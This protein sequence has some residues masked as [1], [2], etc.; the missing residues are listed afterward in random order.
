MLDKLA[1]IERRYEELNRLMADPE[2][3]VDHERVAAL[4]QEQAGLEGLVKA[5]RRYQTVEKELDDAQVLLED[6]T[7][8]EIRAEIVRAAA[9]YRTE[10]TAGLLRAALDDPDT[11]VRIAA[12]NALGQ[13]GDAEAVRSLSGVLASDLDNDV[14]LAAVAALG[15]TGDTAA[16]PALGAA[17]EELY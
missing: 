12:C 9:F 13:Q 1:G 5:Y 11:D 16:V 4:A 2:V 6:E 17:L 8:P 3:V 14:R 10:T 15:R 7:D